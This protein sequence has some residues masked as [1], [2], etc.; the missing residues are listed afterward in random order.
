MPARCSWVKL[1]NPLYVDYHDQEWG[2][3]LHDDQS[4]FELLSLETYQAG[5]SWE[6]VLNK[7]LAFREAFANYDLQTVAKMSDAAIDQLMTNPALIR[8]RGKL[9]AT[10][11]NA[12]AILEIQQT[13][14]S[15]DAYLWSFVNGRAIINPVTAKQLPPAKTAL[16][17]TLSKDMKK[18]GFSFTGPVCVQS[19]LQAAGLIN[20]HEDTCVFKAGTS[21]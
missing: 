16:S 13:L 14:G 9:L 21:R 6:T 15:F 20:D 1:T 17:E 19:F 8:H 2:R 4:L 5:L 7:R 11:T 10:R 18:R 12:R 3:P